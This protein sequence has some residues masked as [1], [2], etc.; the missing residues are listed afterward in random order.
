MSYRLSVLKDD[1]ATKP[2]GALLVEKMEVAQRLSVEKGLDLGQK[3]AGQLGIDCSG[4]MGNMFQQGHVQNAALRTLGFFV[5]TDDDSEVPCVPFAASLQPTF[6]IGLNNIQ[7]A[8]THLR[9]GGGT[10]MAPAL[11]EHVRLAGHGDV[12]EHRGFGRSPKTVKSEIPAFVV[13]VGDGAPQ[14]KRECEDILRAASHRAIFWQFLF[15]GDVK[16]D[17]DAK[18]GWEWLGTLDD[19]LKGRHFDCIDSKNYFEHINKGDEAFYHMMLDEFPGW[20]PQA[21]ANGVLA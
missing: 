16:R 1:V 6:T 18:A 3:V 9:A 14:D 21:R 17:S 11:A 20:L 2:G 4:S 13:V 10:R 15:V 19:A 7:S 12:L 5:M 8:T